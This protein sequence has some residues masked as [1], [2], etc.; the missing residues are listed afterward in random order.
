VPLDRLGSPEDIARAAVYL[1]ENDF[2]TGEVL[3]V[4]GANTCSEADAIGADGS[5]H[6]CL[7]RLHARRG[8]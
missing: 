5:I 4:D 1:V 6:V 2:I 8:H 3:T 7:A